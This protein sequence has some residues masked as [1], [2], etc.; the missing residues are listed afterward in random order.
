MGSPPAGIVMLRPPRPF[1]SRP[2]GPGWLYAVLRVVLACASVAVWSATHGPTGGGASVTLEPVPPPASSPTRRLVFTCI[3][4]GQVV[5]SDRPCGP[6]PQ[7]REIKVDQG[8]TAP[9]NA[10][11]G[12]RATPAAAATPAPPRRTAADQSE[13]SDEARDEAETRARTCDRLRRAVVELDD[14]M[15]A[16]YTAREAGRLWSRWREA[17]ERVRDAGC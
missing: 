5:F 1:R 13:E 6:W 2:A 16:G 15:R 9:S 10:D 17:K 8:L 12:G 3:A 7:I 11:S 14:R 4:P